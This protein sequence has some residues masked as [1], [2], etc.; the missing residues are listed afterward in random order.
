MIVPEYIEI[1]EDHNGQLLA[2][3]FCIPDY[4][5]PKEKGLI[6]KTVAVKPI[7]AARGLGALLVE[8]MH[9]RAYE[10]NFHY[11]IHYETFALLDMSVSFVR[12][13]HA[14]SS[15]RSGNENERSDA[16][17]KSIL[18]QVLVDAVL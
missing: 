3:I 17:R 13:K 15:G 12:I 18:G 9:Q 14:P 4:N 16:R 8:R 10:H 1:C 6:I 2:F 5:S 7:A 11:I